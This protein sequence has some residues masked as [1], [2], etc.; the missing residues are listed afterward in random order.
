MLLQPAKHGTA[1]AAPSCSRPRPGNLCCCDHADM[2]VWY[3][4]AAIKVQL[5]DFGERDCPAKRCLGRVPAIDQDNAVGGLF[6]QHM[7]GNPA[8]AISQTLAN[9]QFQIPVRM[10]GEPVHQTHGLAPER[11]AFLLAEPDD[12]WLSALRTSVMASNSEVLPTPLGPSSATNSG[13]FIFTGFNGDEG[14]L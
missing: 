6:R 5:Q 8:A 3:L 14:A 2:Q 12:F 11:V 4:D 13:R 1:Q 7:P 9:L 10:A